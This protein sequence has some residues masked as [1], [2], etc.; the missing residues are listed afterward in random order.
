[1]ITDLVN[2]HHGRSYLSRMKLR[3]IINCYMGKG[4]ALE[5]GNM[6]E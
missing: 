6:G 4:D 2:H 1:M 5:R 3:P